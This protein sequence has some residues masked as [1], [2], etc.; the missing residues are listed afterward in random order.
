M[1][2]PGLVSVTFRSLS[3][4]H[5]IQL[6]KDAKLKTIEWGGDI[7]VPHGDLKQ[8]QQVRTQTEEAGLQV[9]AYGSYYRVGESEQEGLAFEKVAETAAFLRAPTVRVWAGRQSSEEADEQY[10]ARVIEDSRRIAD[11]AQV[12]Q[13]SISFEYHANTLTDTNASAQHLLKSLD[14]PNIFSYWQP[15]NNQTFEYCYQGLQA[16]S[17]HVTHIHCFHW[18][19][20]GTDRYPLSDGK[21]RWIPYLTYAKELPGTHCVLLEFVLG[22]SAEQFKTDAQ[23][24]QNFLRE[25]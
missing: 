2:I 8:A 20:G 13:L 4:Q 16:I 21:D 25:L 9:A 12:Y 17:A 7:H 19:T 22:D 11:I 15:P 3:P 5:I 10:R 24:L 18:G 14:Y 23:T 6:V 1:L